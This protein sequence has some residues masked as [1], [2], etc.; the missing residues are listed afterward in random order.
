MG[1]EYK[2]PGPGT[3]MAFSAAVSI[4]AASLV[5]SSEHVTEP[6]K[7]AF[8]AMPVVFIGA[9]LAIE[10]LHKRGWFIRPKKQ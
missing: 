8:L 3:A 2:F 6:L 7:W 5:A 1:S 9:T 4:Y 10:N